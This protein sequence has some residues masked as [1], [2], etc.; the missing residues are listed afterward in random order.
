[1]SKRC[2]IVVLLLFLNLEQSISEKEQKHY[3][4]HRLR[5]L[6]ISF[7]MIEDIKQCVRFRLM[8]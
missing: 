1:M 7:I 4:D 3:G 2:S 6:T 8:E 5:R